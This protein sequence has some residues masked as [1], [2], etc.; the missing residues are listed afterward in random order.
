MAAEGFEDVLAAGWVH[1]FGW[2][3]H[4]VEFFAD[5]P[6]QGFKRH[7]DVFRVDGPTQRLVDKGLITSAFRFI[8]MLGPFAQK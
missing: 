4:I 3:L 6:A 5:N 2:D 1:D 7:W 8:C